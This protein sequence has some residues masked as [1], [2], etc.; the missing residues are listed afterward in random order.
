[1]TRPSGV[2][3]T[4]FHAYNQKEP[5]RV[6]IMV[7][8]KGPG[9]GTAA[10]GSLADAITYSISKGRAYVKKKPT[11]K[12]PRSGLQVSGRAI[13]RF[14]V[15]RWKNFSTA[16]RETWQDAYP[17]PHINEYNA[18]I[19]YNLERWRRQAPPTKAFPATETGLPADSLNMTA[20]GGVRHV[21]LDMWIPGSVRDNWSGLLFHSAT[22]WPDHDVVDLVHFQIMGGTLHY[23]WTHTPLAVGTH[24]YKLFCASEDGN[25]TWSPTVTDA[26]V[27]T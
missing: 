20:T 11:P 25:T 3:Q 15:P 18:Y 23:K 10:S 13:M 27:V 16:I 8:L 22:G 19:R 2:A 5:Q 12:Q 7:K 24:R 6:K 17:D 26:A 9:F 4:V 21:E 14:L 1:L